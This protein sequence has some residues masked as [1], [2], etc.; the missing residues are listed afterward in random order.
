MRARRTLSAAVLFV[1]SAATVP[2]WGQPAPGTNVSPTQ[3]AEAKTYFET[4][5]K[6]FDAGD[7]ETAIQAFSQAY[8]IVPRDNLVFSIA[9]AHR[10][11]Y[12]VSGDLG[13]ARAAVDFYRRYV[14]AVPTGGRRA[15]AVKAL[16]DLEARVQSTPEA[17]KD[18]GPAAPAETAD[19]TRIFIN[20]RTEGAV[21]TVDGGPEVP[22]ARSVEVSPGSH[23][24]VVSAPGH[25][26]DEVTVVAR[27][28]EVVPQS[29]DLRARPARLTITAD[30]GASVFVDGRFVGDAPLPDALQLAPGRHYVSLSLRGHQ[31]DAAEL[32]VVAGENKELLGD[33]APTTQRDVA[34][35][36]LVTSSAFLT[37]SAVFVI[38]SAARHSDAEVI[39]RTHLTKN[40]QT[41]D[42]VDY[43]HIV[44]QRDRFAI[45]GGATG[46]VGV[47]VGLIGAGLYAFD[48]VAPLS[49]PRDLDD[50]DQRTAPATPSFDLS[51]IPIIGP[52]GGGASFS[53][54]F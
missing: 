34:Y 7:F 32:Q 44:A 25:L 38:V 54:T 22:V 17:E 48:D 35:G 18:P 16:E 33:L 4:G 52:Q 42:V 41:S 19:K 37:A 20:S 26:P 40:I 14:T 36:F 3:M 2:V 10:R 28:G 21:F 1:L 53:G 8:K 47:V 39:Y 11:Q 49:V 6:A 31:S 45:V 23:R 15:E 24:I 27:E 13:H 12:V 5:A 43:D 9:Q 46:V 29:V 30:S 51:A 50:K